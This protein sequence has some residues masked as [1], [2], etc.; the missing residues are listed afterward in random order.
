VGATA[1]EEPRPFL[2]TTTSFSSSSSAGRSEDSTRPHPTDADDAI[3]DVVHRAR[4]MTLLEIEQ[5]MRRNAEL[6]DQLKDYRV[7]ATPLPSPLPS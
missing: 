6:V 5:V 3:E 1:A 4:L 2:H 7:C